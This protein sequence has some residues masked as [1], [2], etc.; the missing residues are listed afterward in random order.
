M[1]TP[2]GGAAAASQR[3]LDRAGGAT[4]SGNYQCNG[5]AAG[6]MRITIKS[7]RWQDFY[8]EPLPDGRVGLSSRPNGRPYYMI[9]ERR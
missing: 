1:L 2:A 8:A 6:I 9:C 4:P 5:G 3:G 7:G